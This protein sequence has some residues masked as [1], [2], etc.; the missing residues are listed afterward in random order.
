MWRFVGVLLFVINDVSAACPVWPL[1][2][3]HRGASG[4][5]PEHTAMA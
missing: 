5:F 2:I 3:A 4:H 1:V